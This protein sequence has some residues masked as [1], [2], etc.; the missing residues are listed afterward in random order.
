MDNLY[1][2]LTWTMLQFLITPPFKKTEDL[3]WEQ[4]IFLLF[5][6]VFFHVLIAVNHQYKAVLLDLDKLKAVEELSVRNIEVMLLVISQSLKCQKKFMA[7][8]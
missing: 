7:K 6:T 1:N 8:I 4:Q 3:I 5:N 2:L